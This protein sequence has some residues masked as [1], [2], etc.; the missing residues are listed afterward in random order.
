MQTIGERLEEA[1]KRKDV[2]IREAAEVTK[3]NSDYLQKFEANQF[4]IGLSEIYVRGFLRTYANY[5]KL[6]G[7]K[8]VSD[9]RGLGLGEARPRT[10]SRE[11]YGR[12]DLSIGTAVGGAKAQGGEIA[13]V[14]TAEESEGDSQENQPRKF[15]RIGTSLPE[16]PYIDPRMVWR[17]GKI[18]LGVLVVGGIIW[19]IKYAMQSSPNTQAATA[20]TTAQTESVLTL[21]ALDTVRVKVVQK[22]DDKEL[23]QGNLVRGET[24]TVPRRGAL[25][26]TASEGKNLQIEVSGKRY[27]MP[28][29]GY[30]RTELPY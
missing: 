3:I 15:A 13:A 20:A 26:I 14:G 16:G 29:T 21:I 17:V 19:S 22:S 10:P 8:I 7:D 25:Y 28:F 11:V 24:R 1:R 2:T 5:L 23:F 27:A 6:P 30:D 4:D 12:M 18:V 9:Y